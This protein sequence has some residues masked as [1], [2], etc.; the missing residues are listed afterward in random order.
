MLHSILEI[1]HV[2]HFK[3]EPTRCAMAYWTFYTPILSNNVY[4]FFAI[5]SNFEDTTKGDKFSF[6]IIRIIFKCIILLKIGV[7]REKP[8]SMIK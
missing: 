3:D 4:T 2:S 7:V 8:I 1:F 6:G 5:F